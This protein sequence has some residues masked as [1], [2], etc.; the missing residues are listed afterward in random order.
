MQQ[1]EQEMLSEEAYRACG[2]TELVTQGALAEKCLPGHEGA[3]DSFSGAGCLF[4]G[5]DKLG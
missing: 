3:L 5:K 2:G 4:L 1:W